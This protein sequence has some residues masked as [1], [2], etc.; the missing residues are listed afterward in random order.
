VP[1][2]VRPV[3]EQLEHDRVIRHLQAK[4]KRKYDVTINV[5]D[6]KNAGIRSGTLTLYPDLVLASGRKTVGVIEVETTESVNHLEAMAQWAHFGRS[7]TAFYLYVPANAVEMA[8]RLAEEIQVPISEIWSFHPIGDQ[9]RFALMHRGQAAPVAPATQPQA[10]AS[11]PKSA[12]A[13]SGAKAARG[14][15]RTS[16]RPKSAASRGAGKRAARPS[17][18][19]AATASSRKAGGSQGQ[20]RK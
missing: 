1:I 19:S 9:I 20:K 18:N 4:L 17:R 16:A 7:R 14:Q 15:A 3:R 5:G 6:E 2:L 13:R 10:K 12:P 8:R 11:A